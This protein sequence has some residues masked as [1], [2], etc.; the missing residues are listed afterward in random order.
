MDLSGREEVGPGVERW[1]VVYLEEST[2]LLFDK[3]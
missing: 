2:T 3:C 1:A